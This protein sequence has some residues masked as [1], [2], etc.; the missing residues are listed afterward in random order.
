MMLREGCSA[1]AKGERGWA[2]M[3]SV[4]HAEQ[5]RCAASPAG[6]DFQDFVGE[7]Q[8][9]DRHDQLGQSRLLKRTLGGGITSSNQREALITSDLL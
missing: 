8:A 1:H 5:G 2:T 3:S 4:D 6:R 7:K 9:N